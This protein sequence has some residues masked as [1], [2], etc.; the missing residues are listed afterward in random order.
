[1]P[2]EKVVEFRVAGSVDILP[3]LIYFVGKTGV[4]MF[5]DRPE[6]LPR[7]RDPEAFQ[8]F[9]RLNEILNQLALYVKPVRTALPLV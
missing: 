2:L 9:K 5:E 6:K 8:K 3:E 4:A 1:M 7:P